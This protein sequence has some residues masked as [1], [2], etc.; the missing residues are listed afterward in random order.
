MLKKNNIAAVK[1]WP[2][3]PTSET[4]KLYQ[5]GILLKTVCKNLGSHLLL[6]DC[7]VCSTLI[8]AQSV[9]E[10]P[11]KSFVFTW[12]NSGAMLRTS[13]RTNVPK[14]QSHA[15]LQHLAAGAHMCRLAV[16]IMVLFPRLDKKSLRRSPYL[17]SKQTLLPT[18]SSRACFP[19]LEQLRLFTATKA[20][21]TPM[22]PQSGWLVERLTRTVAKQLITVTAEHQQNFDMHLPFALLAYSSAVQAS[23][24]CAPALLM[25]RRELRTPTEMVFWRFLTCT[26]GSARTMLKLAHAFVCDQLH[27][28]GIRQN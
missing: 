28:A 5:A 27:K 22:H 10:I 4:K 20:E 19:A 9:N 1:D 8:K 24:S 18:R 3:P 16:D 21:I 6:K 26:R 12:V 15:Q 25:L 23:T 2:C 11:S 13:Q 7:L 14:D 17:T